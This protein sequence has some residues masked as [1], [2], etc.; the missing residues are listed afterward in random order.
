M[1]TSVAQADDWPQW[2]GPNRDSV[3]PETGILDKFPEDGPKVLWRTPISS[4]YAGPAVADGKVYVTDRVLAKGA[5][6]PADPFDN[7]TE[8]EE[9]R[10]RAVPRREDR[11]GTLEARVRVP[12]PDQLPGRAALHA[13]RHGGK[14]Y[15]LGAMGDLFCLDA[16][17]GK[18]VWS[19]NFPK[20]Y[21]AKVPTWG[22][23]GHPLVY[24]D[25]VVCIVG[26]QGSV[27][28]A[29]DKDTGPGEVEEPDRARTGLQR[30]RRSSRRA[31]RTRW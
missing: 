25:L 19:K 11:Q 9:H 22:F 4:G 23:C 20:D 16:A 10:A 21:G 28:V 7:K 12:V 3:W 26:G 15:T 24:K 18:V 27:A 29:F 30:R 31:A 8:G 6:N 14:V 17:T 13:D 5:T 1:F 2:L